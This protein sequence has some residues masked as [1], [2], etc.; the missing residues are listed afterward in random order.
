MNKEE[1]FPKLAVFITFYVFFAKEF[2][3]CLQNNPIHI[4]LPCNYVKGDY[5]NAEK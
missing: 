1:D 4:R 2:R 5:W 3:L